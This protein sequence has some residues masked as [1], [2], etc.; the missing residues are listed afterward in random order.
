MMRESLHL[1]CENL[2]LI[3]ISRSNPGWVLA[4]E[5]SRKHCKFKKLVEVQLKHHDFTGIPRTS[6]SNVFRVN[7]EN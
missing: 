1:G 4:L 7:Y 2:I 5:N 3:I 6:K